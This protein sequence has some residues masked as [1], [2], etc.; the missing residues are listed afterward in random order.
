MACP[1]YPTANSEAQG[2]SMARSLNQEKSLSL[3]GERSTDWK[4]KKN[5]SFK[6]L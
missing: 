5:S 2:S 4:I 3:K 1:L 6:K